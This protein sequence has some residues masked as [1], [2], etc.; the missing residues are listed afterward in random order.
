M[1]LSSKT[2]WA[3]FTQWQPM[4]GQNLWKTRTPALPELVE[5][6]LSSHAVF[7]Y[8]GE[9]LLFLCGPLRSI[10]QIVNG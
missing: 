9:F 5:G 8:D 10:S 3:T 4:E 1:A 7:V 2:S 6:S